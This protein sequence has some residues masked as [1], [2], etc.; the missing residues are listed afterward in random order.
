MRETDTTE[1]MVFDLWS[2]Q[3]DHLASCS[4]QHCITPF[5][6]LFR[7]LR[8]FFL[9]FF[10]SAVLSQCFHSFHSLA[11]V[12]FGFCFSIDAP[13]HFS[14]NFI[15][16]FFSLFRFI[17]LTVVFA[18]CSLPLFSPSIVCLFWHSL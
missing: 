17:H 2:S 16:S 11:F 7:I 9:F 14:H 3:A 8:C 6:I 5:I 10:H 13:L 12:R 4:I 1:F 15:L 18:Q